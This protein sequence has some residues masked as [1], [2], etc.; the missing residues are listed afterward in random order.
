MTGDQ[1]DGAKEHQASLNQQRIAFWPCFR[2][3]TS[4]RAQTGV[5]GSFGVKLRNPDHCFI[6]YPN[7]EEQVSVLSS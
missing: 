7:S 6:S 1:R 4:P 5:N 3:R 2:E